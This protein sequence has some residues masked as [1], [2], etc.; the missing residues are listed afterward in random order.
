MTTNVWMWTGE[1]AL[2]SVKNSQQLLEQVHSAA[3]ISKELNAMSLWISAEIGWVILNRKCWYNC[4]RLLFVLK[5]LCLPKMSVRYFPWWGFIVPEI[6]VKHAINGSEHDYII[7]CMMLS[8]GLL[9]DT[10]NWG[11]G[12]HRECRERFPRH[13]LQKEIAT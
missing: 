3:D 12:M 13:R 6:V 10:S 5:V 4:L 11:L 2:A 9:S 1:W 8:M 7:C